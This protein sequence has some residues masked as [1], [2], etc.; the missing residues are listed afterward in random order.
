MLT[1]LYKVFNRKGRK[2]LFLPEAIAQSNE[3][4]IVIGIKTGIWLN[5]FS[6]ASNSSDALPPGMKN[7]IATFWL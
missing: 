6:I 7:W 2:R 5:V 3:I 1:R 4:M